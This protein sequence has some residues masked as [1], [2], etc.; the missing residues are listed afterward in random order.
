MSRQRRDFIELEGNGHD[1]LAL[2]AQN[3]FE[4]RM[5][6]VAQNQAAIARA[7]ARNHGIVIARKTGF[8][9]DQIEFGERFGGSGDFFDMLTQGVA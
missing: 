3:G 4:Q 9:E 8:G 1:G 7:E 5:A 2:F 6:R